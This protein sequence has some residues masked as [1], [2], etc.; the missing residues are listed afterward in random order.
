MIL[1][2]DFYLRDANTLAKDLL[3]KTL[4]H[5]TAEGIAK[6]KIV[7]TEA[8][9]GG[10][11][12]ASHSFGNLK[13]SRTAVQFGLGGFAY[14]F[15]IYGMH[16]CF[17]VVASTVDRPEVVL[18]RALEPVEGLELMQKRRK[19]DKLAQ[20]CNG[21]GKLCAAMGITKE[22]YGEDLCGGKLYIE[23]LC[24][25]PFIIKTT[26]RINIDYAGEAKEYL[27]RYLIAGNRF[28]SGYNVKSKIE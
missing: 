11:D 6:A 14:V 15:L 4:V 21:P 3:G 16:Y 23:E 24:C 1:T 13:S 5:R 19:T 22:Q 26:P 9:L 18:I 25:E 7:E 12:A 10:D 20:L 2:R 8:Y 27:W 17:N 28:V